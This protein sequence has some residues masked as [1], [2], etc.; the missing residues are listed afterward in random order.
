[1]MYASF[2]GLTPL[3]EIDHILIVPAR[4][5]NPGDWNHIDKSNEMYGVAC[6]PIHYGIGSGL[7][8]ANL[9]CDQAVYV[10]DDV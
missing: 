2:D 5:I 4:K 8:Q 6:A 9:P 1:M 3:Q 7:M 10:T